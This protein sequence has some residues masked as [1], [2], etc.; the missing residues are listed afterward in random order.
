M[1]NTLIIKKRMNNHSINEYVWIFKNKEYFY[2]LFFLLFKIGENRNLI[3]DL[4]KFI[5]FRNNALTSYYIIYTYYA[6]LFLKG[7]NSLLDG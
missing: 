6:I 5:Q 1:K 3:V 7:S 4:S 2:F